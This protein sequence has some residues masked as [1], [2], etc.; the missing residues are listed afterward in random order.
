MDYDDGYS[1]WSGCVWY[2]VYYGVVGYARWLLLPHSQ[3]SAEE[4]GLLGAAKDDEEHDEA[5]PTDEDAVKPLPSPPPP[6]PLPP[7]PKLRD[8]ENTS[9]ISNP[10]N[11]EFGCFHAIRVPKAEKFESQT[12]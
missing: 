4:E 10:A 12:M 7:R 9:P 2:V 11:H 6:P 1:L 3:L 5:P 8:L